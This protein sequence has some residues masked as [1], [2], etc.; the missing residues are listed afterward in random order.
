MTLKKFFNNAMAKSKPKTAKYKIVGNGVIQV[1]AED[2]L[3]SEK[4]QSVLDA[5]RIKKK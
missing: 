3:K 1:R 5:A 2:L 4:V